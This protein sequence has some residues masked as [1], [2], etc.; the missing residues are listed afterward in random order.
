[1]EEKRDVEEARLAIFK[2][3]F[4]DL[5]MGVNGIE[6]SICSTVTPSSKVVFSLDS[7]TTNMTIRSNS[8]EFTM[9]V[10]AAAIEIHKSMFGE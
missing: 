7:S 2:R 5:Y 9:R 1:M 3:M 10:C 8:D 4:P 6:G